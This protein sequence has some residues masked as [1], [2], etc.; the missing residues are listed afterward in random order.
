[1]I[2]KQFLKKSKTETGHAK[3]CQRSMDAPQWLPHVRVLGGESH[4]GSL[5]FQSVVN[6]TFGRQEAFGILKTHPGQQKLSS[7]AFREVS[8]T[9]TDVE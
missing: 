6:G 9:T 4:G 2:Y 3:R 1:M 5:M 8:T 7:P